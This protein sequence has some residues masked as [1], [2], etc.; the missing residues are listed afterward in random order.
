MLPRVGGGLKKHE[1]RQEKMRTPSPP[2]CPPEK[3]RTGWEYLHAQREWAAGLRDMTVR[4]GDDT[5]RGTQTLCHPDGLPYSRNG[6]FSFV[7]SLE[8]E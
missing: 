7:V 2:K 3:T 4:M 6:P 1:E 8:Q 5:K